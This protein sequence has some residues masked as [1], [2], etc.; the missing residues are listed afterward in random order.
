MQVAQATRT[1]LGQQDLLTLVREVGDDLS[2][3]DIGDDCADWHAQ[4]DVVRTFAI[5]VGATATF[6]I[7]GAVHT[8]K[9]EVD[10]CV[11]VAVRD[12]DYTTA[13]ST[14]TAVRAAFFD[15]F[16]TTKTSRAV[17]AVACD[18]FDL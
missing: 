1:A 10:Q 15:I 4:V 13:A 2:A 5:A 6:A 9:T 3:V 7:L 16:L 8:C 12:S 14:V 11:D 18:D 17:T